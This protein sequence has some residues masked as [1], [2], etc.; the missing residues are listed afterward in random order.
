MRYDVYAMGNAL[1]DLEYKVT[2]EFL[3]QNGIEKGLMTLVEEDRQQELIKLLDESQQHLI[4][5]QCGGSAA[6]T[7]MA[8]A[9]FG[10]T[11]FYSCRVANDEFGRF[12]LDDINSHG[13]DSLYSGKKAPEGHSG[14]CLVLVTP[15]AQ[16]TMLTHLGISA[17]YSPIE[18]D[19][20]AL[21]QSNWLYIEGYLV[22][23]ETAQKA[24]LEAKEIA[25]DK[26][27]KTA[28]TMSDPNMVKF[29]KHHID[30]VL[31][32]KV[33]LLFCNEEEALA[34]SGKST[35]KD[36]REFL[37]DYAHRFAITLG[38]NGAVIWDG[39]T[40]I[41]IESY[42][43]KAIDTNGAGDMFAGSFLYGITHE[44]GPADSGSFASLAASKVVGQFGPRLSLAES[45]EL[46]QHISG[47]M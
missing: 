33:D 10:G 35:I 23:S 26:G 32:K 36:A 22:A 34:F 47:D 6:N 39:T 44:H 28:F 18:V 40:Y 16:R 8:L 25:E 38:K 27:V 37:K 43:V 13:V 46:V 15:D 45:K 21:I 29:F 30:Q 2:D 19:R 12:Y 20:E 11:G 17:G 7:V 42:D 5:K 1:V 9:Q 14:T 41:D 3:E 24:I 4:K 31:A